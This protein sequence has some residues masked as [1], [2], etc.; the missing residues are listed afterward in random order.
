MVWKTQMKTV[1]WICTPEMSGT[2]FFFLTGVHLRKTNFLIKQHSL[3]QNLCD[4]MVLFVRFLRPRFEKMWKSC[5]EVEE[6]GIS[7]AFTQTVPS[8]K[9][10]SYTDVGGRRL[11]RLRVRK[12]CSFYGY[13]RK[14]NVR[15]KVLSACPCVNALLKVWRGH[16]CSRSCS[17]GRVS[18]SFFTSCPVFSCLFL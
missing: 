18:L 9:P 7:I 16:L 11:P 1:T 12:G 8:S 2:T 6:T 4:S 3:V 14:W 5:S 15:T 17:D 10:G 13:K